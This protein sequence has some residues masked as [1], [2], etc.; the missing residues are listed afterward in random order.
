LIVTCADGLPRSIQVGEGGMRILITLT[1]WLYLGSSQ[2]VVRDFWATGTWQNDQG[3]TFHINSLDEIDYDKPL[4]INPI[5]EG[6]ITQPPNV[7]VLT[8]LNKVY[9]LKFEVGNLLPANTHLLNEIIPP[10]NEGSSNEP[11]PTGDSSSINLWIILMI[12]SANI[13]ICLII[14]KRFENKVDKQKV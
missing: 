12:A 7:E 2:Y 13:Y 8:N 6:D 3:G 9:P 5:R 10:V 14:K 4:I 11:V 1:H